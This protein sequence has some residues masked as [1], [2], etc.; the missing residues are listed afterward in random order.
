MERTEDA[1]SLAAE[2]MKR[3]LGVTR[4]MTNEERRLRETGK[5]RNR[6]ESM[7]LMSKREESFKR[8][9]PCRVIRKGN[10]LEGEVESDVG[11]QSF[12]NKEG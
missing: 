11:S 8:E 4:T 10:G 9:G 7:R 1:N 6:R 2:G 12:R 5:E 3:R